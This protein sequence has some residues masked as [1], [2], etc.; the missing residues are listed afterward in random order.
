M[1]EKES[2]RFN[3]EWLQAFGES[4]LCD[5]SD[6]PRVLHGTFCHLYTLLRSSNAS[7]QAYTCARN[8]NKEAPI[9]IIAQHHD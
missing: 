5:T 2:A 1:Y 3:R 7:V 4:D 9:L 6:D 8:S